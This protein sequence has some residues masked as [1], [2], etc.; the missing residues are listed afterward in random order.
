MN[1]TVNK[2]SSKK[3][4]TDNEVKKKAIKLVVVHL[5]KKMPEES[6]SGKEYLDEWVEKVENL[7]ENSEFVLAEY[8]SIRKE[9]NEVIEMVLDVDL[10]YKLRDSWYSL[11]KA[12]DK[13]AKR[14]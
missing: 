10:R 3:P 4:V 8:I 12:I 7:L 11:G 6:Y 1:K 13:K 14:M 5:K 9:L 2:I